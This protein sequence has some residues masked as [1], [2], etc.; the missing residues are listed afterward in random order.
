MP[1]TAGLTRNLSHGYFCLWLTKRSERRRKTSFLDF[2][3]HLGLSIPKNDLANRSPVSSFSNAGGV[4]SPSFL[5]SASHMFRLF[6]L[7]KEK[8]T[9]ELLVWQVAKGP[10]R[11]K[12]DASWCEGGGDLT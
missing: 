12:S 5:A 11:R 1:S 7:P 3:P 8:A 9:D 4:P 2:Q 6:I 10:Y